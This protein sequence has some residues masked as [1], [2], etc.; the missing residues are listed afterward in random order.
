MLKTRFPEDV[1]PG[2]KHEVD[3][4][5]QPGGPLRMLSHVSMET[6]GSINFL[7]GLFLIV[8]LFFD[9]PG[10]KKKNTMIPCLTFKFPF[11]DE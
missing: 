2:R 6:T 4:G 3:W 1:N 11:I 10:V 7:S 9:N 5:P 8:L